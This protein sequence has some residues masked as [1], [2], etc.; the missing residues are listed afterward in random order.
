M[1]YFISLQSSHPL[2]TP[3]GPELREISDSGDREKRFKI[4][5]LLDYPGE[6]TGLDYW[7]HYFFSLLRKNKSRKTLNTP[8]EKINRAPSLRLF[9]YKEGTRNNLVGCHLEIRVLQNLAWFG[10]GP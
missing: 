10:G 3:P 9:C 4:G 8:E 5:S 7:I 6:L 2:W 1:I